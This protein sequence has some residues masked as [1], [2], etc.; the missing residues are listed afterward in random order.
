MAA[1]VSPA[2]TAGKEANLQQIITGIPT[3]FPQNTTRLNIKTTKREKKTTPNP[4]TT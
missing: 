3:N 2:F 4:P 1:D